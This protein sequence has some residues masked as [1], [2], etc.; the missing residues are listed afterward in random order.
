M[1]RFSWERCAESDLSQPRPAKMGGAA[2]PRFIF[3]LR[4]NIRLLSPSFSSHFHHRTLFSSFTRSPTSSSSFLTPKLKLK[5]S[6]HH[7]QQQHIHTQPSQSPLSG[8]HHPWPE[9]SRFLSHISSAGYTSP[10][11][12]FPPTGEL[13]QAEVSACL[14]FARDRPNLLRFVSVSKFHSSV[15]SFLFSSIRFNSNSF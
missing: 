9:F 3:F 2:S 1:V 11:D 12:G 14:S 13:P 8:T 7:Q 6:Q 10:A 15:Y 4:H 5:A